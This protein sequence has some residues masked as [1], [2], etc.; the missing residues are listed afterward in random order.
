MGHS[1]VALT[2]L[3]IRCGKKKMDDQHGLRVR[4]MI[5]QLSSMKNPGWQD[6][7]DL[8]DRGALAELRR[9]GG[10]VAGQD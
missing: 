8:Q 4:T 2:K 10:L 3:C 1:R 9:G 7:K 6:Q 5:H